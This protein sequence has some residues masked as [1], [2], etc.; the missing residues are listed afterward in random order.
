MVFLFVNLVL[1]LNFI[2]AILSDTYTNL[3]SIKNGLYYDELI[4]A[5][6]LQDW[7]EEYGMLICAQPP[8]NVILPLFIPTMLYKE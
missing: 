8:F 5:F 2:I 4:T 3:G 7:N 1:M 6:P